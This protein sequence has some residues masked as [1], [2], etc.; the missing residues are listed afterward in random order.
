MPMKRTASMPE[1]RLL[2]TKKFLICDREIN[3]LIPLDEHKECATDAHPPSVRKLSEDTDKCST[4]PTLEDDYGFF[5]MEEKMDNS[6]S[7]GMQHDDA[8]SISNSEHSTEQSSSSNESASTRRRSTRKKSALRRGSAYGT[9]DAIPLD[10]ERKEFN[11]VLPKPNL[12]ER[13][14]LSTS[15]PKGMTRSRSRGLFRVSSEP[16]FARPVYQEE[17]YDDEQDLSSPFEVDRSEHSESLFVEGAMKKRISFGTIKIREHGQTIGDNP[18]C[19]YGVPITLDW[20]HQDM[21]ELKV[22]DYE[23]YRPESR[24]KKEFYMNHFQRSNL[25]K[26]NGHSVSEINESKKQT[27]KFRNQRE[28]TK[29]VALNYPTV[30]TVEDVMESG[31][32]KFKRSIS[33][34]KIHGSMIAGESLPRKSSEDDLNVPAHPESLLLEIMDKDESNATAPF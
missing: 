8:V 24:N 26:L 6:N 21:D 4:E 34:S 30:G 32:R 27:R 28:R 13:T 20:D 18:S 22:E 29:F 1:A 9:V 12:S 15:Q 16:V 31:L 3:D 23:A 19:S 14:T 11:R 10:F 7:S 5:P 33:K 17:L 2:L 25:L